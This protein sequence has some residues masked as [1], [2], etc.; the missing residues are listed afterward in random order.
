MCIRDRGR[1]DGT[2][3][4]VAISDGLR[5]STESWL[6]VLRDLK[7]R[8]E[9]GVAAAGASLFAPRPGIPSDRGAITVADSQ[10]SLLRTLGQ[11]IGIEAAI[12]DKPLP[13]G[14]PIRTSLT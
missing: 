2:Q 14:K 7:A 11:G 1:P 5:E 4:W 10:P 9:G 12:L 6:D 8:Q 3:E 13:G